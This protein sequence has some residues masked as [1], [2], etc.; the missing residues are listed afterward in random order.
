[1]PFRDHLPYMAVW[2]PRELWSQIQVQIPT[3]CLK[4]C[5]AIGS[6]PF[7]ALSPFFSHLPAQVVIVEL[8]RCS[9][10]VPVSASSII[11]AQH[12]CPMGD[13]LTG[14]VEPLS[15]GSHLMSAYK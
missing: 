5:K 14:Q 2:L 9:E 7:I 11:V 12:S 1:M 8:G 13:K 15:W 4:N 6:E 10:V 3:L